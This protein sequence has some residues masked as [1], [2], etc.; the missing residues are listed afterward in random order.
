MS[1]R[2]DLKFLWMSKS[3]HPNS[4]Y[5]VETRDLMYRFL[6]DGWPCGVI[7][8][9]GVQGYNVH[10]HGEDLI[11]ERFKG[12]SLKV[13]PQIGDAYGS[14]AMLPHAQNFGAKVVFVMLDLFSIGTQYLDQM[15][16]AG[17]NFIPYLPIDQEPINPMILNNLRY[18]Y[19]IITFSKFGQ[20]ALEKEG[21]AS[22]LILE[23]IDP[24]I[25]KP[26]DKKKLRDKYKFP[27]DAFLF[28]MVAANK[29]NI[30][31]KSF[32]EVLEAF[33]KFH[34]NHANA[35]IFFHTQQVAPG[36]FPILDYARYLGVAHRCYFPQQYHAS[37]GSDS[38]IIAEEINCFDVYMNPS[39]T[40]GFGLG[41]V[42]SQA[43]GVPPIGNRCHSMPELVVE[44]KTGWICETG[45]SWWRNLM[46]YVFAPNVDSL[47]EKMEEAY[48]A[49]TNDKKGEIATAA[50]QNVI[51]NYHIDTL[52]KNEWLP[53]LEELQVELLGE[54]TKMDT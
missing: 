54:E 33:A 32:Q 31:R 12:L 3:P 15:T 40:E 22:K 18:A 52:V 8:Q 13:Y 43:C 47:V 39:M 25:F 7:G 46:G 10:L 28:G 45:K 5:A 17:V 36:G 49:L 41:M 4:G 37:F 29:E 35:A 34:Q 53:F 6:Q 21:F 30:P 9:F 19:K 38:K 23:G 27:Q 1:K 50:R 24:E 14:D 16:K 42:E 2:R 11:D 44:G 20:K 48:V 51:D 26:M